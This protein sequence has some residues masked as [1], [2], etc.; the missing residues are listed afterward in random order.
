MGA[1]GLILALIALY[2][3]VSYS[4]ACRTREIGIRMAIGAGRSD[5]LGMVLR[6]GFVLSMTGIVLGACGS[7]AVGRLLTAGMLGLGEPS[8]LAY[9]IVPLLL[10]ALTMV[11]SYVPARRASLVDPLVAVRHE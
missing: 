9:V 4:V 11:A 7:V 6:Q 2:G 5:V 3:L 1:V 8:R 10:V